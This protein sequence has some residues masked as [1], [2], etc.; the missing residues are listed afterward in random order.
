PTEVGWVLAS[1]VEF[2]IPTDLAQYSEGRSYTAVKRINQVQDPLAGPIDWFV[3]GERR[4]GA[5]PHIDFDGISV[6]T[7]NLKK[8]RYDTAFR[9]RD[10]RGVYPLEIGQDN[11]NPTI[12]IYELEEDLSTKVPKEYVMYGVIVRQKKES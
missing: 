9:T 7:W 5:N 3:V 1:L 6:F 12:H 10:L 8:H 2:D 11:G 4:P